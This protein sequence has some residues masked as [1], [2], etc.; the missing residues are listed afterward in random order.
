MK[1]LSMILVVVLGVAS[2][3]V[4]QDKA[5]AVAGNWR[6]SVDTPHGPMGGTLLLKQEGSKV[7]GTCDVEH[8]GSM[9]L[10]G[11]V[12]NAKI[13]LSIELPGGDTFKLLGSV[14]GGKMS[15]T[16]DPGDGKWSADRKE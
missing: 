11:T 9:N 16:T 13:S 3:L 8:M 6:L 10:T 4:A 14:D 1:L 5:L 2:C 15:G 7:T 12:E